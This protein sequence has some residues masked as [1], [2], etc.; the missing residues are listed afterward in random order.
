MVRISGIDMP[1][2]EIVQF[3]LTKLYGIGR[4]NALSIL[5][6]ASISAIKRVK[7]LTET[8]VSHLQKI[9]DADY[10][11]EGDLRRSIAEHIKRLKVIGS[12]RGSRHAKGLPA[13]GQ[14][15]KSNARTKRGKRK[16]VGALKKDERAKVETATSAK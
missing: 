9:I 8:E 13:R 2:R 6:K 5:G 16:T 12:Y 14:R 4:N 1:D 11:V 7:D 3:A 10:V 15:T